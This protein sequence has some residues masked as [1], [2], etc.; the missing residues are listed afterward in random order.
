[1]W[2]PGETLPVVVNLSYG[3]HE[4][5]HDGSDPLEQILDLFI[6]AYSGSSTP[7]KIVLAA[8]NFRQDRVHASFALAPGGT[9]S[10]AWRLQPVGLTA[11]LME[12]WST[13]PNSQFGVRLTSPTGAKIQVAKG[14]PV[15]ELK[16]GAGNVIAMAQFYATYTGRCWVALEIVRTGF[17]P[18]SAWNL[19][20]ADAGVWTVDVLNGPGPR[21]RYD[22]WIRRSD[23][24][25]GHRAKGRQ[26]YFDDD[27]YNEYLPN[28]RSAEFDGASASYVRR[29]GK[30]GGVP[31]GGSLSGIASGERTVVIGGYRRGDNGVD[32]FPVSYSSAGEHGNGNRGGPAPDWLECSS[33]SAGCRGVLAA[34]N[35]SGSL[36]A[37]TGTSAAAPL[38]TRWI[39]EE[40]L[41]TGNPPAN[42]PLVP[43]KPRPADDIPAGELKAVVGGGLHQTAQRRG[44]PS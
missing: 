24:P 29:A 36:A 33:D 42:P 26:S 8:G 1:M 18:A 11:S 4:G 32:M 5:P 37:I 34:A 30:L 21:T 43:P 31:T 16:D 28:G 14:A 17:D 40:W 6:K 27:A 10:L 13:G 2:T 35:H 12:V 3:P 19:G 41:A 9:Q 25:L 20:V 44:R 15:A 7:L 39:A 38:A 22:A 23:T